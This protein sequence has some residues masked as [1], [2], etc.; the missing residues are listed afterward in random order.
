MLIGYA[1]VSTSDQSLEMQLQALRAAGCDQ[2]FAETAPGAQRERP[3]LAKALAYARQGDVLV[4]WKLD[5]LGRS[6]IHLAEVARG[7]ADRGIG[8]RCLH[9]PVDTTSPQ[10]RL[11]YGIL[12]AL[13]EFERELIRERT[14]AAMALARQRGWNPRSRTGPSPE[15]KRK[16]REAAALYR[17]GRIG[18]DDICARL[19]IARSTFYDYLRHEGLQ[20]GRSPGC[21]RR[22]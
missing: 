1:R 20:P 17:D 4:V 8:L 14:R 16:A 3:E 2:I 22:K 7:L 6:L 5:R 11:V 18:V 9:G 15:G 21:G 13:A 12:A 10:G 19:G